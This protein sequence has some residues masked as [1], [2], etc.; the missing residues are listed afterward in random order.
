MFD[1]LRR[2]AIIQTM[3]AEKELINLPAPEG[4]LEAERQINAMN[5]CEF[6]DLLSRVLERKL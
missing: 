1:D 3:I 2:E 5:N 4:S 6:L